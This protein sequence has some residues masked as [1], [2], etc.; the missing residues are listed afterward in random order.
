MK[1]MKIN[2]KSKISWKK[3]I[4]VKY[5]ISEYRCMRNYEASVCPLSKA[6]IFRRYVD[7]Y[8]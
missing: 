6:F 7:N 4:K 8:K 1:L 5:R 3:F 2:N